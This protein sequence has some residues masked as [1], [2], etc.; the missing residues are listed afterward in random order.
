MGGAVVR[1]RGGVYRSSDRGETWQWAGEGLPA[2]EKLFKNSEFG[3]GG[4]PEIFFSRD[5]SAAVAHARVAG[6]VFWFDATVGCW[7]SAEGLPANVRGTLVADGFTP[8]RFLVAGMPLREST[9]G[10][11]TWHVP[12][13]LEK[14]AISSLAADAAAPG[15]FAA[16]GYAAIY[17]SRDGAKTFSLLPKAFETVPSSLGRTIYL[18]RGRLYFLTTG[19]G[20]WVREIQ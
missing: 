18:D 9:D 19:T 5:G 17:V 10:G 7:R 12:A 3:H 2:G 11:R 14:F 15:L 20:V 13:G 16:V 8:G 4:G 6:K 1:G